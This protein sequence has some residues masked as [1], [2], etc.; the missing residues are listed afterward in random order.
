[1]ALELSDLARKTKAITVTLED[2]DSFSVSYYPHRFTPENNLILSFMF[3]DGTNV[4]EAFGSFAETLASVIAKWD[5]TLEGQP[6]PVTAE[7]I[8]GLSDVVI[9]SI[10]VAIREDRRPNAQSARS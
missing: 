8:N 10:V 3:D 5:I 6:W 9:Q 4:R 1:M 7:N 2:G